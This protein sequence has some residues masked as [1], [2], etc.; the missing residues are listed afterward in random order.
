MNFLADLL[1]SKEWWSAC[2]QALATIAAVCIAY[3]FGLARLHRETQIQLQQ[4]LRRRQT[5]ALHAAWSLLQCLTTAANGENLLH[6]VQTKAG[7]T[8]PPQRSYSVHIPNAQAFVFERLPQAFYA[9]GAG[10][11]WSSDIKDKFFQ[12]RSLIYGF[13]LAQKQAHA[14][15]AMAADK[16]LHPVDNPHLAKT[17]EDLYQELNDLLRKEMKAVYA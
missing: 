16:Q 11:H 6:H 3:R 12:C 14:P 8:Q 9:S 5:D 7:G 13:L 17:L 10:L 2:V 1:Q 15:S 4:D